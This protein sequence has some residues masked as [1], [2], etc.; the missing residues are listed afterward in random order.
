[1]LASDFHWHW[2]LQQLRNKLIDR[3]MVE[4]VERKHDEENQHR[5]ERDSRGVIELNRTK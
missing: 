3:V 1:M 5:M 4:I 2:L